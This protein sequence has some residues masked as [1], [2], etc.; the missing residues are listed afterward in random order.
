MSS[1]YVC[2]SKDHRCAT[3]GKWGGP[4]DTGQLVRPTFVKF[5]VHTKGKCIGGGF[6][7]M[8]MGPMANC[9]GWVK[10]APLA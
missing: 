5:D 9:S 2:S 10:W 7:N 8:Q 4:R 3:C 1:E 6:A